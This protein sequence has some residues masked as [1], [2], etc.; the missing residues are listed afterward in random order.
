MSSST[1]SNF[2]LKAALS[3]SVGLTALAAG[4]APIAMAQDDADE[5][6]RRL[7]TVTITATKREQTLQDV[8]VA[9][10]VVDNTT[11]EKAEIQDLNDLQSVVPSLRVGQLQSSANTNF[12]IRG[13]GNGANNV[14]IEPSV[15]VFVDGVYRSRSAAQ[16]SDLPNLQRVEVLRGPQSTLFGKN[17]SAG[18][19]SIVTR[20]PQ[21]ETQGSIEATAGNFNAFRMKGDLTGP[22]SDTVAYSLAGN[23]NTRD[24]YADDIATGE[25]TN[26]RN[27]WGVRGEL[28]FTP[29]ETLELRL[30]GD[31][32][33]IDEVCCVA[34]NLVNGPTGGLIQLIGGNINGEDPFSYEVFGN[35]PSENEIENSGLSLQVDK[36]FSGF[37]V[38]SITAFRKVDSFTNQDSD[39]TSAD[40]IGL[41]ENSGKIDTF[42]QEL[43]FTSNNPDSSFD[44]M[45]GGF[46]F[47]ESVE[48][49][50]DF[51][52]GADYRN[53]AD[54]LLV[55]LGAPGALAGVETALG[56][57]V[58]A[59]FGQNGQ[60]PEAEFG[61][62][63]KAWSVFGTLDFYLTDRL[64]A[65]VG[66][67]YTEDEKDAFYRQTN[68]DVFSAVDLVQLGFG[69]ALAGAGVDPTDPTA[70]GAFALANPAAFAAI[71]AAAAD[72]A[73]N[74][75]LGLQALQFLP[76][77]LDFPNSVEDGSSSDN[78][79]THTLRVAYDLT[80]NINVYGSWATGFKATSWNL[81]RDS[82]PFAS[83]FIAGSSVTS[84]P[85]S[86]IRDAGLAVPNL[87][88]GTRFAG[89][90]DSEVFEIGVKGA[91]STFAFNLAIFDQTIEGFQSNAFT[92]TGFALA[93]AGEQSTTGAEFDLTW[94][95]TE[96]LTLNFAG[97][98]LD[99]V[100]DSFVGSASGDLSGQTPSGIPDVATSMGF[101]YDF[102]L[103]N[104]DSY[105]RA[106]WQYSADTDFFDDPG[107]QALIDSVGYSREVNE[108]NAAAG[109]ENDDGLSVAVWARNLLDDQR[110][111]TAFPSVAQAG[112]IS[113]YPNQ[114]RTYGVTLR[115]RF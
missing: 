44:W 90:E 28:L 81:S 111:T 29:S 95:A 31:Y 67:N 92:G 21:F 8:P 104:W 75:L 107:N 101:N 24:G 3:F 35:F 88:S 5:G 55:G 53:Y 64:T 71:Q 66:L 73:Q 46:Y 11:I 14:G 17:A 40:L 76:P 52:Y 84:P 26:E 68:S 25:E 33:K 63:N 6:A 13:F 78:A 15:G 83:D 50:S 72:P 49:S 106:D 112:S 34:G 108:V 77:F 96:A 69:S 10:S 19:I 94:S 97:T 18:V 114:P 80:D 115:K 113:G 45:V 47:D 37:D 48:V 86:P 74:P 12:I 54:G 65:T 99:P 58:G 61:Q 42:T 30:I 85:S 98:F 56:L 23:I 82:R 41:N 51:E 62:D 110:I 4:V 20:K 27:R 60:G 102:A 1:K 105:V 79:T 57:P 59:T 32:D 103:G 109:F 93:N 36:E 7:S 22:L 9:V 2:G 100:Y 89:P 43:R 70:V 87:T 39:F 16:I 91:F 38:T